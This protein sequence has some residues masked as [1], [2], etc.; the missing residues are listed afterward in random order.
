MRPEPASTRSACFG[1]KVFRTKRSSEL[2][3][4]LFRRGSD[5][6]LTPVRESALGSSGEPTQNVKR[7]PS[8][9]SY[10]WK[11]DCTRR[12]WSTQMRFQRG[13][14]LVLATALTISAAQKQRY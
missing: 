4:L 14:I 6:C 10:V 13:I 2:G 8:P 9:R 7:G 3:L 11:L 12:S 1:R 5:A